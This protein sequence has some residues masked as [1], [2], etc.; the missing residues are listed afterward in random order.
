[1][2]YTGL[3]EGGRGARAVPI[4]QRRHAYRADI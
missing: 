2:Q 1:M 4:R 3:G